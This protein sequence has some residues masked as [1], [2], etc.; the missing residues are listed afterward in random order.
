MTSETAVVSGILQP[1]TIHLGNLR[2]P[3]SNGTHG[4]E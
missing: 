1:R 2:F 4:V 3:I